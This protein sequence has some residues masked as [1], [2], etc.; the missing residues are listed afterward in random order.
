MTQNH[1]NDGP[2]VEWLTQAAAA[3]DGCRSISVG[4]LAFDLGLLASPADGMHRVFGRF[5]EYARRESGLTV[6]RLAERADVDLAEIVEIERDDDYIPQV[7][8]VHQIAQVLKLPTSRLL[9]V[10]GLVTARSSVSGAAL[11]FAAR[12]EPTSQLSPNEREAFEEFVKVLVE[13]SDGE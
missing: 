13:T 12:S 8:T 5:V 4:G 7:R 3:E 2:S 11:K 9:Q 6:E 1:Q 10:A